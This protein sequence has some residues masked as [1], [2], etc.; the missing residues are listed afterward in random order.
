MTCTTCGKPDHNPYRHYDDHGKVSAGC[1][2]VCHTG[3]LVTPSESARWHARPDAKRIRAKL[4]K[5][6]A[7]KGYSG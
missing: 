3:R 4:A 7:G 5:G 2:D 1:V 6:Q